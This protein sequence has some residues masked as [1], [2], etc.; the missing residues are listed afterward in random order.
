MVLKPNP[1]NWFEIPVSDLSRA[2]EFYQHIF[3]VELPLHEMGG[4]KMAWFPMVPMSQNEPG[5]AGS[6]IK[7]GDSRPSQSGTCVYFSVEDIEDVLRKVNAKGG[8]TVAPKGSIG[9]YGFIALFT[10]TEGNKVGLHS[11]K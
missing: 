6:L 2:T 3:D 8:K 9:E 4:V 11:L 10:D 1:V 7:G 5:A